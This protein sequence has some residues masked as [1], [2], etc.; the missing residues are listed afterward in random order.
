MEQLAA[1]RWARVR[2]LQVLGV[3]HSHPGAAAVPSEKDRRLG[4]SEGL[5]LITDRN[6]VP[7]A[8]WLDGERRVNSIP[9][10]VWDTRHCQE[11]CS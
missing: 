8:W 1:Q 2:G 3:A 6:G 9:V 5:M 10:E 7:L 11:A 4:L